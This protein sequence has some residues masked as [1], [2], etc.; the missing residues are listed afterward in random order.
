M[1]VR[2]YIVDPKLLEKHFKGVANHRRIQILLII[3]EQEAITLEGIVVILNCN[4]KTVA[5]HTR[6]LTEANLIE[7]EYQGRNVIHHL[8]PSGKTLYQFIKN[9]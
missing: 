6:R 1:P 7:K 8:S 5:E 4:V 9:F 3:A 2:R